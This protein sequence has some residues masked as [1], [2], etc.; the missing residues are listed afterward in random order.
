M[1]WQFRNETASAWMHVTYGMTGQWSPKKSKH[2]AGCLTFVDGSSIFYN[3]TRRFGTIKFVF[4][5][6]EHQRKLAS[7]GPDMLSE[8]VNDEKF[9]ERMRKR[10][11][12][13]I[14]EVL[15]DQ[16]IISGVGNYVKAEALYA[17]RLSPHRVVAK[18]TDDELKTLRYNI[19]DIMTN[20]YRSGG[21]TIRDYADP[22][23]NEGLYGSL[24]KVYGR[25][26][27]PHG[28][29]V[30]KEETLDGRTTWWC[31]EEQK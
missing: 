6:E 1:H 11:N 5:E 31:P 21:A 14:V 4:S 30:I 29:E 25:S 7:L 3:D 28:N 12:K 19:V 17:A 15:L 13:T 10:P 2:S 18:I 20:S 24:L 23:G 16:S 8:N 9:I 27:D 22:E 26:L